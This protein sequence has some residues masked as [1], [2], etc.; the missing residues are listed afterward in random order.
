MI[1]LHENAWLEGEI[2]L[3]GFGLF[4]GAYWLVLGMVDPQSFSFKWSCGTDAQAWH[5]ARCPGSPPQPQV[6]GFSGITGK[7]AAQIFRDTNQRT[8]MANGTSSFFTGDT[9]SNGDQ[10]VL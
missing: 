10:Q 3:L 2:I 7:C 9:S 6:L 5:A 8:N 1:N 4:S